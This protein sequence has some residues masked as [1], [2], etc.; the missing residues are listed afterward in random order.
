[1]KHI[2]TI[3]LLKKLQEAEKLQLEG[4]KLNHAI[5]KNIASLRVVVKVLQD[6]ENALN[7]P[8]KDFFEES[9]AHY[10]EVT[11]GVEE[12]AIDLAMKS[13]IEE[14]FNKIKAK[15]KKKVEKFEKDSKT[16]VDFLNNED[17]DFVVY[18]VSI[19]DVPADIKT[20]EMK[21]IIDIID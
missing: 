14:G 17:S 20:N 13:I 3:E 5:L 9:R 2:K 10:Q 19:D 7:E 21:L 4:H 16:Y 18:K 12:S 11:K 8:M 1:M 6:R 15:H